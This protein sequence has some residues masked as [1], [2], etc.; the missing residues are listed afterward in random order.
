MEEVRLLLNLSATSVNDKD[1]QG[2]SALHW[3]VQSKPLDGKY[4][5]IYIHDNSNLIICFCSSLPVSMSGLFVLPCCAKVAVGEA[6]CIQWMIG[7][8]RLRIAVNNDRGETP[9]H[10]A[11]REGNLNVSMGTGE[12]M[13]KLIASPF[14]SIYIYI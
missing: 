6:D 3:A 7:H 14:C 12:W 13:A 10:L 1:Y 9:L 2:W 4:N 11:A 8:R 5:A